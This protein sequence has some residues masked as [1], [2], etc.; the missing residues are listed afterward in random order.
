MKIN[1]F[2]TKKNL[3][4][5]KFKI[6]LDLYWE[7]ILYIAFAII[8]VSFAFGFY[9]FKQINQELVLSSDNRVGQETIKKEKIDKVL[10][11]FSKRE[12][13]SNDILNSTPPV[14]DP[15]L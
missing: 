5:E 7:L 15:S 9:L 8:L 14:I 11:Y 4:K 2:K 3:Q 1:F 10:D 12:K 13:K 6:N